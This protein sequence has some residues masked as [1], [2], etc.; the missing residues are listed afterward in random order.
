VGKIFSVITER[1][2]VAEVAEL[3]DDRDEV[4][5]PGSSTYD[6]SAPL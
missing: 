1:K 4:P 3:K 5:A 2:H 6:R